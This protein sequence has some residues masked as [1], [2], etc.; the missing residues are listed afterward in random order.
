MP[1]KNKDNKIKWEIERSTEEAVK[2][3]S[4]AAGEAVKTITSA[5]GEAR[6]V[7]SADVAEAAKVL[8]NKNNDGTSDHDFLLTFSAEVKTKLN[9]ISD[10]IKELKDGTSTRIAALENEKLNTRDSYSVLYKTAV[11]TTFKDHEDR[12]RSNT[13]RIT[14]IMT[15][16]SAGIIVLGIAE[17]VLN[18]LF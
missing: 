2:A 3:I 8:A 10:D 15:W 4:A 13:T 17:F 16:G 7:V 5:A 11:E 6:T 9:A 18:L 1:V 14:Q 12:L